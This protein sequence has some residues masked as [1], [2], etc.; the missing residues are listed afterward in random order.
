MYMCVCERAELCCIATSRT[1]AKVSGSKIEKLSYWN[2]Y[3]HILCIKRETSGV[4]LCLKPL[5]YKK[6]KYTKTKI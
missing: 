5:I 2:W 6:I 1:H 4:C 3:I